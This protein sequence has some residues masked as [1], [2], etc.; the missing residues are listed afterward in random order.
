M[1]N[2]QGTVN[3]EI[4]KQQAASGVTEYHAVL[5]GTDPT[6]PWAEQLA[7]L[8]EA[9]RQLVEDELPQAHPV[10]HRFYV[11][12]A[13]NQTETLQA[14][15]AG[16]SGAISIVQQAP[17][18]GT[19][20][21]LWVYLMTEVNVE[22]TFEGELCKVNHGAYHHLWG[23]YAPAE[24]STAWMQMTDLFERYAEKLR[25][26]DCSLT[27]NSLRTW[28]FVQNIDVNYAGVVKARNEVFHDHHLTPET[29]FIASTGIC[30]RHAD[31]KVCVMM[32]TYAVKGIRPEQVQ[33]LYAPTHL[34]PTYEYGVSFER[35]TCVKYGDR[36]HVFI[37]G[38]ASINNKGEVMYPGDI[39]RQTERMWENVEALLTEAE[40]NFSHVGQMTV[41]L[42]DMADY[43]VVKQ[44]FDERF[45]HTPKVILLAPVCRPGWLIE[46]ECMAVKSEVNTEFQ[47]L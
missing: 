25:Q 7:A 13:A 27:D 3:T 14:A 41:Y 42:R 37:S 36:R 32:D 6:R 12:D 24:G 43:A 2:K 16:V 30:G 44:L 20:L 21:A 29:H 10:F 46:M 34:N 17:L 5:H 26:E 31:P 19:K 47:P 8:R 35:G 15:F 22:P 1:N 45:P 4:F 23:G 9:Y 28:I 33:Y 40:C 39:R 18:D 11:S 38:T